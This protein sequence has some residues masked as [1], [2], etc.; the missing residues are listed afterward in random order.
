MNIAGKEISS[1]NPLLRQIGYR[2]MIGA[3]TV[4]GGAGTAA[5]NI[6]SSLTGVT[7][8]ELDAFKRSFAAPWNRTSIL[9]PMNKWIKGKGKAINFSYFSPYDVVQ[10]PFEAFFAAL[11]EGRK[12]NKEWDDLTLSVMGEALGELFDSFVSEPIGYERIIDVLPRGKFGREGQKKAG[13]YVY[14]DTDSP[15]DKWNKSFAHVLEGIEPGVLTTGGKIK[16]AIES[17]IKPGG[18]PYSLRDEALALFSGIRIIDVNVPRS[19]EYSITSY[20]YDKRAVTKAE[21]FYSLTN[22]LNR[23]PDVMADEFRQIQDESFRVQQKF[24][25][26]LQ[27]ALKMGLTK[28]DVKKILKARGLGKKEIRQLFRGR[29][30]PA[31]Y[32]KDLMEKRWKK[33]KEAYKE[34]N[35]IKSYF[36]PRS[37][38][39]RVIR[40]YKNRSLKYE[41]DEGD[42]I[43]DKIKDAIIPSAGAAEP[44]ID[45]DL[46]SMNR[47]QT[48][49]LP[50]T[51]QPGQMA[52]LASLQKNPMTGLT[53]T[54]TALLSPSEQEIARRT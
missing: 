15:S 20:N 22:V 16:S 4:L 13:G 42:S 34:D 2:R 9:L 24:Y 32:N 18:Q 44:I 11:G 35:P 54:E 33:A 29:F 49:P 3:Y 5:L 39:N 26:V 7:L 43:L 40:E 52:G 28:R 53:R 38:L 48:P 1:S 25:Y 50:Q 37:E 31:N 6:A 17:D 36:Y 12:S 23:G 51:P 14:S 30:T 10:K 45:T 8:E 21:D 46:Q 47:V 19:M 41:T 27:D